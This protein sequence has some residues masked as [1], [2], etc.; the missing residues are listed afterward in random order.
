[1]ILMVTVVKEWPFFGLS[2]IITNTVERILLRMSSIL[3]VILFEKYLSCRNDWATSEWNTKL[4]S[5]IAEINF[6]CLAMWKL[7]SAM[8]FSMSKSN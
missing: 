1:M 6:M 4:Q 3:Q 8:F 7:I 2:V 5:L